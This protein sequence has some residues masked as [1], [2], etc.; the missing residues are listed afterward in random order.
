MI[1]QNIIRE[2]VFKFKRDALM[3]RQELMRQSYRAIMKV[4]KIDEDNNMY[5]VKGIRI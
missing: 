1:N 4:I 5:V 2:R 3:F